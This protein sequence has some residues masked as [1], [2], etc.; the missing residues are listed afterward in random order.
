[1]NIRRLGRDLVRIFL[2]S[3]RPPIIIA[4]MGRSGSTL[5]FDSVRTAMSKE[6]FGPLWRIMRPLVSDSAWNLANDSLQNGVVYKTH[7]LAHELPRDTRALVIYLFGSASDSAM[8]VANCQIQLGNEWVEEHFLHMRADG[9]FDE[10]PYRDVLRFGEQIQGWRENASVPRVLI[11]YTHIWES[12]P[13]VS[14]FLGLPLVL[15]AQRERSAKSALSDSE[16]V[17]YRATYAELDKSIAAMPAC[18]VLA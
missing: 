12:L 16:I 4:S 15:E 8:S 5:V 1:M 17:V 18:E 7:G 3:R 13:E 10:L 9:T 11:Q 14:E 2:P 6:R